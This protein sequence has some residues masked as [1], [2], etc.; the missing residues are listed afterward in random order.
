MGNELVFALGVVLIELA[1]GQ[2]LASFKL[3]SDLDSEGRDFAHTDL[4]VA[5][6]LVKALPSMEGGKYAD[7]A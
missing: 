5:L 7:A 3:P 4:Q 2:P 1:Y 6:R